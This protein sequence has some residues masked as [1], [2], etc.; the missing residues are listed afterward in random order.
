[1]TESEWLSCDDARGMIQ[2]LPRP[3][4]DERRGRLFAVACCR[5]LPALPDNRLAAVIETAERFAD[6]RADDTQLGA[7]IRIA[8]DAVEPRSQDEEAAT[9][10]KLLGAE[11]RVLR[12]SEPARD[13]V[14]RTR[15]LAPEPGAS[16]KFR[17]E[18]L[19]ILR[20]EAVPAVG[21]PGTIVDAGKHGFVVATGEGGF[22]AI[23]L[24]PAGR[25]RM[26]ASDFVNGYRAAVGERLG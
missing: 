1:M 14:N 4:W 8:N 22:R 16:A 11:D 15:A 5:L 3:T 21:E 25:R 7:A 18:D 2:F 9:F 6:K 19:K 10:T 20:A 13:L 12:W 17:G 26:R 23:E 24:A